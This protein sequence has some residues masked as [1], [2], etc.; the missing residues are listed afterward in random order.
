MNLSKLKTD[1]LIARPLFL[2]MLLFA[3]V[4]Y[5]FSAS[6]QCSFL[7]FDDAS[8]VY[9]N[10]H[11]KAGLTWVNFVWAFGSLDYANW[12]P[13]TWLSHMV[14]VQIYRLN[15]WGHHLTSVL[16]HAFNTVL[17]FLV[18]K[19]MTGAMWRSF[20]VAGLF[21]L[22]PLRVESVT[23]ISERKDVLC[24][25]FW[26]L[27]MWTYARFAEEAKTNGNRRKLFYGVT[28]VFFVLA[29]M[30]KTMAVTFPFALLLLDYWPLERW[31]WKT[32]K[33][34]LE[35]LPFFIPTLAV[36]VAAYGA[37]KYGGMMDELIGVSVSD[38]IGN[39]F[40]SYCRYLGKFFWPE[41][42]CALYP[43][44]GRWPIS[45]VLPAIFFVLGVSAIAWAKRKQIPFLFV[46][47]FW[48]LGT[49]VPVIGLVQLSSLAMADRYTYIPMIGIVIFLVWQIAELAKSWNYQPVVLSA[50]AG[51]A[52]VTCG[53]IT[54][55]QIKFWKNDITVWRRATA[56]ITNNYAAY[57]NYGVTLWGTLQNAEALN[58]F[59]Q[60]VKI[61]QNFIPAQKWLATELINRG[62]CEEAIIHLQKALELEPRSAGCEHDLGFAF[63]KQGQWEQT[64]IHFKRAIELWPDCPLEWPHDLGFALAQNGRWGEALGY[65]Q[66]V[67]ERESTNAVDQNDL[68]VALMNN[69]RPDEGI[70]RFQEAVRLDPNYA[71]ARDNLNRALKLE[72]K[73]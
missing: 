56:V 4:L 9:N 7:F 23:W 29:L 46:G 38:R 18:L 19:R 39:A 35:K 72:K 2:C 49:L 64:I 51:I 32:K 41:N 20:A 48:Y 13:L 50:A 8:Y 3:F 14:D 47:W 36:S 34:I 37:Q 10:A 63:A 70:Q 27:A 28:F 55:Y 26:L 57:A 59:E 12:H 58:Q 71:A 61:N 45:F 11:V 53:T 25:L 62:R 22:H 67:A 66:K 6:L 1:E 44:P 52:I 68:G 30:S 60:A 16:I 69:G 15:P 42:L 65:Y 54:L 33:L 43:H 17:V 40:I 21:G 73:N 31:Q 24:A 5:V